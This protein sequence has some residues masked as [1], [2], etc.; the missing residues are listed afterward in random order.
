MRQPPRSALK[1]SLSQL[2]VLKTLAVEGR[3]IFV[4]QFAFLTSGLPR[5][6]DL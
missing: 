5:P 1:K 4:L 2:F 6:G 3:V